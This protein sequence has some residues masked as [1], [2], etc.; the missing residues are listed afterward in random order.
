MKGD[1]GDR[2]RGRMKGASLS[3]PWWK[4]S[5][6]SLVQRGGMDLP[7]RVTARCNYT[8]MLP[9]AHDSNVSAEV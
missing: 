6:V 1:I 3:F 4:A 8:R 9:I 2:I 7:T 5:R